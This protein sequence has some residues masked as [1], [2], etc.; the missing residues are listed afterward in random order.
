MQVE[1]PLARF[2]A[3]GSETRALIVGA[4]PSHLT[5]PALGA[6]ERVVRI[7][8]GAGAGVQAVAAPARLPFAEALFDRL[9]LSSPLSD[10]RAELR[11][12][13]R[14][15]APAGLLLL[16]VPARRP[17]QRRR[18]GWRQ[19]DLDRA[20]ADAMFEPVAHAVVTVPNRHWTVLAA[21]RDGLSPIAL[22]TA[23]VRGAAPA[24]AAIPT[25]KVPHDPR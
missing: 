25:A 6:Y 9:L 8:P 4:L 22:S 20:L 12:A 1:S 10:P 21:K 2:A 23:A 16:V 3:G 17:W 14:V 18:R 19:G 13:W 5:L 11:E 15:L 7:A 24:T